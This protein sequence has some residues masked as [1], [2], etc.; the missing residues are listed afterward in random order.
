MP[1]GGDIQ[2]NP[3]SE[4]SI[5]AGLTMTEHKQFLQ[6][7]RSITFIDKRILFFTLDYKKYKERHGFYL[8]GTDAIL[9][10]NVFND[11]DDN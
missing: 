7:V 8:G 1:L 9:D 6:N 5:Y 4:S 11:N 3:V 2:Q 10:S